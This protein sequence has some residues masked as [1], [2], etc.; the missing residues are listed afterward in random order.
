MN[1]QQLLRL[2]LHDVGEIR[3][4]RP[5]I[6]RRLPSEYPPAKIYAYS[7]H[8]DAR[9][10]YCHARRAAATEA[11]ERRGVAGARLAGTGRATL[12]DGTLDG[13]EGTW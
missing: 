10:G 9:K 3:K 4:P 7:K 13:R 6:T 2:P 1:L 11:T 8:A 5:R 12:Q